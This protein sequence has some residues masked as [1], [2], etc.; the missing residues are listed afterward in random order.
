MTSLALRVSVSRRSA[1]SRSL[2]EGGWMVGDNLIADIG[3]GSNAGLNT[4]WIDR[5][6]WPD[7]KQRVIMS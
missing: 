3:D 4:I 6:T 7:S 1:C 5:G 2:A